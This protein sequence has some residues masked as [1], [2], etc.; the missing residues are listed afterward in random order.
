MLSLAYSTMLL[1]KNYIIFTYRNEFAC[2][3]PFAYCHLI[4][5]TCSTGMKIFL[6]P[7]TQ[8]DGAIF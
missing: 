8:Q 3:Y 1:L 4:E 7:E 5:M 6:W 2:Q